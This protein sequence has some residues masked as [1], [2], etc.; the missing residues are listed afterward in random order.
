MAEA[1][2]QGRPHNLTVDGRHTYYVLAG[3]TPVLVHNTNGCSVSGSA[4]SRNWQISSVWNRRIPCSRRE[5]AL[6]AKLLVSPDSSSV[7][8]TWATNRSGLTSPAMVAILRTGA[9]IR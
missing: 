8:A 4:D 5:A 9:D 3:N 6:R 7:V 1:L 2:G